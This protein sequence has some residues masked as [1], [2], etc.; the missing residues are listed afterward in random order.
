M[1]HSPNLNLLYT[2]NLTHRTSQ[3]NLLFI[4]NMLDI[5]ID[6]FYL[7]H[8]NKASHM[9]FYMFY[10]EDKTTYFL[11][12]VRGKKSQIKNI[13]GYK[14]HN[15]S[16]HNNSSKGSSIWGIIRYN[17]H[18]IHQ[19]ITQCTFHY[20]DKN[21]NIVY[22]FKEKYKRYIY[23]SKLRTLTNQYDNKI[24]ESTQPSNHFIVKM[25]E[26]NLICNSCKLNSHNTISICQSKLNIL[27]YLSLM[28]KRRFLR[29][30]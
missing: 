8:Q 12:N 26:W 13:L 21:S 14:L 25:V 20:K 1:A 27:S 24:Q 23:Q 7:C 18:K 6:I 2:T 16:Y 11:D 4:C 9:Y 5:F 3:H 22:N 19:G 10:H 30:N 28:K 15:L 17:L 29:D